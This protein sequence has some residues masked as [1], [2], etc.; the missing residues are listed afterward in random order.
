MK[1]TLD[2]M[3]ICLYNVDMKI[4]TTTTHLWI[5][6]DNE[7][8][9]SCI[10]GKSYRF[11]VGDTWV[12]HHDLAYYTKTNSHYIKGLVIGAR[13]MAGVKT[14]LPFELEIEY[15]T[16]TIAGQTFE[17][18][19]P[20]PRKTFYNALADQGIKTELAR[21]IIEGAVN[22]RGPALRSLNYRRKRAKV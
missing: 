16:L 7:L 5:E 22:M 3:C 6:C 19:G 20:R 13:A 18:G 1:I 4:T 12:S 14:K 8:F 2:N 10:A 17:F 9:R 21:G 15:Q 11:I